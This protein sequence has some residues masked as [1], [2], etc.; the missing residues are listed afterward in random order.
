MKTRLLQLSKMCN[1]IATVITNSLLVFLTLLIFIS[2]IWGKFFFPIAWQYETTVLCLSWI[3][4]IGMSIT[5]YHNE[6]LA[7]TFF[8]DRLNEKHKKWCLNFIDLLLLAFCIIGVFYTIDVIVSTWDSYY[9][10]I[11][12]RKGFFYL[13]F[14]IGCFFSLIH[15][16]YRIWDRSDSK[17][18]G[19]NK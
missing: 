4:F 17:V 15:I 6:H 8:P 12:V 18:K 1:N 14:P 19:E 7:L 13:P 11:P 2:I 9:Q 3:V 5:F 16:T 10:T